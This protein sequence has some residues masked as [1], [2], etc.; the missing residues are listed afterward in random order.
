MMTAITVLNTSGNMSDTLQRDMQSLREDAERIIK[1]ADDYEN[2][3]GTF[4]YVRAVSNT[5]KNMNR[6]WFNNEKGPST[7]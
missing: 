1:L 2:G 4:V 3:G 5:I 6:I 7:P